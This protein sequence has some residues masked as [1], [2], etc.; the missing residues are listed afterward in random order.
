MKSI[1][2]TILF[3]ISF[4]SGTAQASENRTEDTLS[5][6]EMAPASLSQTLRDKRIYTYSFLDIR[7]AQYTRK[8]ID[9]IHVGLAGRLRELGS[10]G[11]LL[12]YHN[13]P[14]GDFLPERFT[15]ESTTTAVPL[16]GVMNANARAEETLGTELRLIV[17]PL[18]Y[19]V[20]GAWRSYDILWELYHV[21]SSEPFWHYTYTGRHMTLWSN[22]ENAEA[23]S[24]KILD[25]AFADMKA[26]GLL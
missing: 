13:T 6:A 19:K 26:N 3:A 14:H 18:R 2:G 15:W 21:G 20:E 10:G 22:K 12:E 16:L 24:K 7:E 25:A 17:I 8:L 1:I 11:P 9:T 5:A 23:R 4:T